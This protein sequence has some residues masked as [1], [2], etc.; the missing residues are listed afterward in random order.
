[1]NQFKYGFSNFGGPP[2]VNVTQGLTQYNAVTM[3]I[4]FPGC[5]GHGQALTEFPT[6][7]FAGSNAPNQWGG[8]SVGQSNTTVTQTYTAVD[9]L[10]WVKGKH[11]MTYGIQFQWLEDQQSSY[12]GPTS[13][14]T[15]NYSPNDTAQEALQFLRQR[16]RLFLRFLPVGAVNATA[17]TVQPF[18]VLG[19]RYRTIA[20]YFEDNYQ[21]HLRSSPSTSA[22]AGTTSP[23]TRKPS[24][25]TRSSTRTSPIL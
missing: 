23:L 1:M 5:T 8:G 4:N 15:F 24:L 18:S 2:A 12:D 11:A 16:H 21:S 17:L 6:S 20:P 7:A 9:N 22:F 25:A 3:G 14:V 13:T 10:L 19:G